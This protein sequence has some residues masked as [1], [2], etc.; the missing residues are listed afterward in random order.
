[1]LQAAFKT[2]P[3]LFTLWYHFLSRVKEDEEN[4]HDCIFLLNI[5]TLYFHQSFHKY[6]RS[7]LPTHWSPYLWPWYPLF[8]TL[9]N[10]V[11]CLSIESHRLSYSRLSQSLSHSHDLF[12]MHAIMSSFQQILFLGPAPLQ[13]MPSFHSLNSVSSSNSLLKF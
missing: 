8:I 4:C 7:N 11:H 10:Q 12:Q 3:F 5:L 6:L 1:M 13:T 2:S 9:R